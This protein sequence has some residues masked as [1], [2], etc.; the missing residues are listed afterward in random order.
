M[1]APGPELVPIEALKPPHLLGGTY[2]SLNS[3]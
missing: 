1:A 3:Y 2:Q